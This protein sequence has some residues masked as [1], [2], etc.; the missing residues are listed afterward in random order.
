MGKLVTQIQRKQVLK[1]HQ[2]K[3]QP[4]IPNSYVN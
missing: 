3:K 4:N 2:N 1:P